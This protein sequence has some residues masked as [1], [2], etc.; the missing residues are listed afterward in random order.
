M[1]FMNQAMKKKKRPEDL[2][3]ESAEKQQGYFTSK[4]AI[5]AGF[6]KSNHPY[7]VHKGSWI[8]EARGIYRLKHFPYHPDSELVL[9]ML[10]SRNRGGEPQGVYSHQT[11]LRLYDLSDLNP[12][13]LHMTVPNEFRRSSKIPKGLVLHFDDLDFSDWE[14][15]AGYRVTTPTRTLIDLKRSKDIA[16]EFLAQAVKQALER[17]IVTKKDLKQEKIFHRV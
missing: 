17:G 14:E 11:A 9:W 6:Q 13:K 16:E 2:L 7:Y 15:R 8:R 1:T 5:A 12:S 4:Q 3:F 10:W